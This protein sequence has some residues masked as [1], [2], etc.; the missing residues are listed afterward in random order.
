MIRAI[1]IALAL[2][3]VSPALAVQPDEV[4]ADPALELRA[5]EISAKVRC[6][7]CQNTHID[8]SNAP[9]A[10]DLRL[11]VRERL[12]AGDSDAEVYEYL[13]ARYGDFVLFSPPWRPATY[14][15][16][17]GPFVVMALALGWAFIGLRRRRTVQPVEDLTAEERAALGRLTDARDA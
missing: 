17:I 16:W 1:L 3:T 6:V 11:L 10:R 8:G 5:R 2:L 7:V 9:V 4:L 15:L 14:A 13:R 12:T